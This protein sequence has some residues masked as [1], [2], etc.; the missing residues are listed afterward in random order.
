[1]AAY[2]SK[3]S[4]ALV[5]RIIVLRISNPNI[6]NDQPVVVVVIIVIIIIIIS[7]DLD[8]GTKTLGYFSIR[9]S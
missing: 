2:G 4:V 7:V 9:A 5:S 3:F 1:V 6:H 8:Q